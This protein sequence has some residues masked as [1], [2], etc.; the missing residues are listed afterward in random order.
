MALLLGSGSSAT[1]PNNVCLKLDK[2]DSSILETN[3]LRSFAF[4]YSV[5]ANSISLSKYSRRPLDLF[6]EPTMIDLVSPN[7]ER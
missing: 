2:P 3:V 4:A 7:L 6:D 5:V 1:C